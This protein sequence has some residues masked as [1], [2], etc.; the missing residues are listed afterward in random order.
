MGLFLALV[1]IAGGVVMTVIMRRRIGI[2]HNRRIKIF[3]EGGV[4]PV[5]FAKATVY[6]AFWPITVLVWGIRR[7][8]IS[9]TT[10]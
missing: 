10:R 9:S 4:G 7:M 2:T 5:Y 1:Y 6:S 3:G 8:L